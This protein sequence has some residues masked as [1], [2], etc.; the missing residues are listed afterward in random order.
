M[1][2][3]YYFVKLGVHPVRLSDRSIACLLFG[4]RRTPGIE[5]C[6]L[7]RA[8]VSAV[9]VRPLPHQ[10][11]ASPGRASRVRRMI[12]HCCKIDSVLFQLQ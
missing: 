11:R 4:S 5:L 6:G 1:R 7:S 10:V 3:K 2:N 12:S 9:V 8:S